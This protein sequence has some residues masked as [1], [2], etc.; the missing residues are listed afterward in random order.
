A[1]TYCTNGER[2]SKDWVPYEC[3]DWDAACS[4]E[5]RDSS[6]APIKLKWKEKSEIQVAGMLAFYILT[7]GK[8]P[9]G[10]EFRRQQNLHDG[11][12]VGLS[13]LS[14]PVVKDL[15]SQMLARDLRERPYVEQALKH[16]YFLPSEDQMKFLEAL[17]NEPEIKSFKGD[18]SCAV[19]GELDNRD[20]SRPRSSLLPNDWKAVIDPDDLKT[21]CAG[22]PTRPSRF[23]GSRYTQCLRFIRNVRQHWGDKPRPPLKAMGTAT[24]LDEY[25]LQ[26][27]P[28][29]P[30]VV[31][32]IIRK[33]PDWKTRLSLKEFFPVINRRAGSDAD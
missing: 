19:S 1:T 29:L 20:L 11:N 32:Q 24:S 26:L 2:G 15:L 6:V 22:G 23:D 33:H 17:G 30:L 25:F 10:P 5:V 27:F 18:R 8:H 21:F 3:I 31:H 12:P 13:K 14:D 28:T 4:D 9:F 7:K 16:P